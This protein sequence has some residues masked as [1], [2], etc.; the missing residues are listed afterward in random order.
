MKFIN[1]TSPSK[2]EKLDNG[3][4][5]VHYSQGGMSIFGD[6]DTVMLAVGRK[7]ITDQLNLQNAGIESLPSGKFKAN[8]DESL[9]KPH[10]FACGDALEGRPE[11]T[12]VA[13]ETG[14]RIA[15]RLFS[16]KKTLMNYDTIP[17]TVFTPLEYGC[18]GLSEEDAI[19]KHGDEN[20]EIYHT[21]F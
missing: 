3:K 20:I 9:N 14:K 2:V 6:Y 8:K 15:R 16:A 5:R 11:L 17:T 4:L 21:F 19:K 18:I 7:I 10:V 13:I 1:D 12:P